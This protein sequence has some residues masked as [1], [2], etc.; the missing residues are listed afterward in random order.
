MFPILTAILS[1]IARFCEG[2]LPGEPP[3]GQRYLRQAFARY[4]ESFFVSEAKQVVSCCVAVASA[5]VMCGSWNQPDLSRSGVLAIN[6][7]CVK[8]L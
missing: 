5:I 1:F 8:I 7:G 4:Y 2:L 6:A 3:D